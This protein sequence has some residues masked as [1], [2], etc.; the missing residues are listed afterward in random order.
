MPNQ[1]SKDKT[2]VGGYVDRKLHAT[3]VRLARQAGMEAN[4]FGFVTQLIEESI[5]RRKGSG[6]RKSSRAKA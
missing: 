2:Y 6:R 1:R 4:R 5:Q 3:I